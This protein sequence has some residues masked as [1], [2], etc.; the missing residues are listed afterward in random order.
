MTLKNDTMLFKHEMK[1][2][3]IKLERENINDY[4]KVDDDDIYVYVVF[5]VVYILLV[6]YS[7]YL[8]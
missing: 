8:A 6:P 5:V 2:I 3:N 4:D 1:I 7:V